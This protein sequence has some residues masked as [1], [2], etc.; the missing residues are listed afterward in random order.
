MKNSGELALLLK[1]VVHCDNLIEYIP[2]SMIEGIY[3]ETEKIFYDKNGTPYQNII[4]SQGSHG[5]FNRVSIDMYQKTYP[6]YPLSLVKRIELH[7]AKANYFHYSTEVIEKK[8]TPIIWTNYKNSAFKPRLA[9]DKDIATYYIENFPNMS[10]KMNNVYDLKT[11][12]EIEEEQKKE[13][14]KI[15]IKEMYEELTK[16]I[17]N[18]EEPIKQILVAIWK[19][20]NN[21]SDSKSRN[22]LINGSTGVGKTQIF[23]V[24]TTMLKIPHFITS[25][26]DY[27]ATGYVGKSAEDMLINI[28][29]NA[30][31]NLEKAQK[32]ILIIDEID[33]LSET[34][35]KYSQI[36]QRD[37]QEALLKIL[38]DGVIPLTVKNKE[39][40]F[41]TKELMVIGLGSWARIH[42]EN[43]KPMGFIKENRPEEKH[44]VNKE[45]MKK[46]GMIS[47]L[48]GRFPIVVHMN[49]LEEKHLLMIL[50]SEY[51]IL[52]ANKIF[53]QNKGVELIIE[54]DTEKEIAKKAAQE[55]F[56]ARSL[57]EIIETALS[58]ASF[59]IAQ[60][61]NI[62]E[63]LII[64]PETIHNSQNYKLIKK[65][66]K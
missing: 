24:L 1:K 29:K 34:N 58:I 38:E 53:F 45:E 27:S 9:L 33:K 59:E 26:T 21:F 43:K 13:N 5:Y 64:S 23:R 47:E 37:V 62:Y 17:I 56:G 44:E 48:L 28:L 32:G 31:Y 42:F 52:N 3:N 14:E 55:Q 25:A 36:N 4:N 65:R 40:L 60:N 19:Q 20:Y 54:E 51:G 30:N 39:Y 6:H 46:N 15:N 35:N 16:K 49:E 57:D 50:K 11:D 12:E 7:H 41:N 18:Q 66:E 63:K 22:I 2:I 61:P 8:K 10:E